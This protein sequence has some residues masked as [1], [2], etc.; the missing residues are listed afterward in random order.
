[1]LIPGLT[2]FKYLLIKRLKLTFEGFAS[3]IKSIDVF[4]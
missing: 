4:I 1:M 3:C 2:L